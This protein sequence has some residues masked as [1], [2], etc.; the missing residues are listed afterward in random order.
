[1]TPQG[2]CHEKYCPAD[3]HRH[4][5]TQSRHFRHLADDAVDGVAVDA[6][7]VFAINAPR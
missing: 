1:V 2:R 7:V 6:I 3:H 5:D 4:L